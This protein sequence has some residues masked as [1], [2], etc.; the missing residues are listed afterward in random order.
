MSTGLADLGRK[1]GESG[2]NNT[3]VPG[4]KAW[5]FR[6]GCHNLQQLG[7]QGP[8]C[9]GKYTFIL[10]GNSF[11]HAEGSVPSLAEPLT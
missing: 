9:L 1:W 2:S 11:F 5:L 8:G 10:T 4:T 3:H 6:Q 7:L